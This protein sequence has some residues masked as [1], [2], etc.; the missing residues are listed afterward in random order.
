MANLK[1]SNDQD[2]GYY[3]KRLNKVFDTLDALRAEE[4][5]DIKLK[6]EKAAAA[7]EKKKSAEAVENAYKAL[8]AAKREYKQ[9]L[10]ALVTAHAKELAALQEAFNKNKEILVN[11]LSE[12][13]T[14]Y[15]NELKNFTEKHPEGFHITLKDGDYETSISSSRSDALNTPTFGDWF[16]STFF[17]I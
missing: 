15:Q 3:S 17:N 1:K 9:D 14:K 5:A 6:E 13:E 10:N 12:A 8:N 2:Y 11:K 7:N 16:I 4:A